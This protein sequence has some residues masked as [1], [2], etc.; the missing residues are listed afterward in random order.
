M[1]GSYRVSITITVVAS[2][3]VLASTFY[4]LRLVQRAF[5]GPNTHASKVPDLNP[6][7]ALMM[8]VLIVGLL[9]LGLYPQPVLNASAKALDNSQVQLPMASLRR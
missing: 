8:A 9:G 2:I 6:R 7:E 4:A 5:Q 3:G 1:L